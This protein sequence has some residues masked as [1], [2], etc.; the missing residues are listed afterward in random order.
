[1]L[2]APLLVGI[3][4]GGFAWVH[5]PLAALWFVGYFAFNATALWLKSGRRVDRLP[6]VRTYGLVTA[7]LG[8]VV[9]VA[10]PALLWWLPAFVVSL[11][12]GLAAAAA[13]RE[14]NLPAGLTTVFAASLMAA[15]AYSAGPAA[16]A[17]LRRGWLLSLVM[18]L[19]FAGTVFFVKSAIRERGN[20]RFR[21]L[22]VG[23]HIVATVVAALMSPWLGMFF[24]LLTLRAAVLPQRQLSPRV[25]GLGEL[26]ATVAVVV[27]SLLVVG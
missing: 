4:A 13:R 26:V 27:L 11:G 18:L 3:I 9:A 15:V 19:Y 14:R 21:W 10:Q 5:V 12:I 23:F 2:A 1:M 17:G 7:A 25:L 8:I 24:A 20:D 16:A 6:P 22:S